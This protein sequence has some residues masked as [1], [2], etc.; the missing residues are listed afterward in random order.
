MQCTYRKISPCVARKPINKNT[1]DPPALL[2]TYASCEVHPNCLTRVVFK[3][4]SSNLLRGRRLT[5]N[6]NSLFDTSSGRSHRGPN[7]PRSAP[8]R[9][10]GPLWL[11]LLLSFS[12]SVQQTSSSSTLSLATT[13]AMMSGKSV[14]PGT[15]AHLGASVP[16]RALTQHARQ[17]CL[18]VGVRLPQLPGQVASKGGHGRGRGCGS[19]RGRW[20]R[21]GR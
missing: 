14:G 17:L 10:C 12:D 8:C 7:L 9:F 5:K 4:G 20:H 6:A 19:G 15:G 11:F 3:R 16:L 2:P 13:S 1:F 18:V 21:C